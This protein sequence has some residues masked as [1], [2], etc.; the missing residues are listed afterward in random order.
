M[1]GSATGPLRCVLCGRSR[2]PAYSV[3]VVSNKSHRMVIAH[4]RGGLSS[5]KREMGNGQDCSSPRPRRPAPCESSPPN[6][7]LYVNVLCRPRP[8]TTTRSRPEGKLSLYG[9]GTI[10]GRTLSGILRARNSTNILLFRIGPRRTCIKHL[11]GS[12]VSGRHSS[13]AKV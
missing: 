11:L 6:G 13:E 4:K 7:A 1:A 10:L 2:N 3:A 5:Q 12:S 9:S 8:D